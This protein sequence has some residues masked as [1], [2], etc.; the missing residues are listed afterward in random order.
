MTFLETMQWQRDNA[1]HIKRLADLGDK[2]A[3]KLIESYRESYRDQLNIFKQ[4]EWM[5]VADEFCRR[6]L[7]IATREILQ[8]RYGHKIPKDLRRLDS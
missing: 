7:T 4:S 3:I 2:L 5:K 6:D 1:P 8:D